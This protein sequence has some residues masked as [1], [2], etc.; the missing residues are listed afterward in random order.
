MTV[1]RLMIDDF[2]HNTGRFPDCFHGAEAYT[3]YNLKEGIGYVE[4]LIEDG[5]KKE[6]FHGFNLHKF[7]KWAERKLKEEHG[8]KFER[9]EK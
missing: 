4:W 9:K 1:C 3:D 2:M 6:P 7:K 8:T 5:Y